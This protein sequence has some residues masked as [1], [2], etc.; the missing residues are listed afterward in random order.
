MTITNST[1]RENRIILVGG[2][3]GAGI[4]NQ[5]TL[6]LQNT[7]VAANTAVFSPDCFGNIESLGNNLLGDLRHCNINLQST[8]L[9]GDPG[10]GSLG[11]A[12]ELELLPFPLHR[13]APTRVDNRRVKSVRAENRHVDVPGALGVYSIRLR[14]FGL[15]SIET[16]ILS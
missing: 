2:P 6:R 14:L 3:T 4:F 13:N 12:R 5:G 11:A 10:L 9:T 7:L 8:D 16:S 1:I 15:I